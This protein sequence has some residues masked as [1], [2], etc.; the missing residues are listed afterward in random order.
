MHKVLIFIG[1]IYSF[2]KLGGLVSKTGAI[3]AVLF[4]L[5]IGWA[6]TLDLDR[7]IP[8]LRALV[9]WAMLTFGVGVVGLWV[10]SLVDHLGSSSGGNVVGAILGGVLGLFLCRGIVSEN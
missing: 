9:C 3:T 6:I 7:S 1:F 10:G 2:G 4:S 5:I 8:H